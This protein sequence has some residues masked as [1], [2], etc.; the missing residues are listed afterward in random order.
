MTQRKLFGSV[1]T[2]HFVRP[3][4]NLVYFIHS[5]FFISQLQL[6][7]KVV[8]HAKRRVFRNCRLVLTHLHALHF[9]VTH[10]LC[11]REQMSFFFWIV[12]KHPTLLSFTNTSKIQFKQ[13]EEKGSEEPVN[14]ARLTH[15]LINCA[16]NLTLINFL[17]SSP[18]LILSLV[19][20]VCLMKLK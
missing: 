20:C 15:S 17:F 8:A 12:Y 5:L 4:D 6:W 3:C 10:L 11:S 19:P 9:R 16:A 7:A 1:Y 14:G 13:K 2:T 18:S